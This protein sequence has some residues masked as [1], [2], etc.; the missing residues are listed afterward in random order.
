V[1]DRASLRTDRLLLEPIVPKHAESM[2]KATEPSLPE[3]RPWLAWAGTA[4]PETTAAFTEEARQD[5]A[6]GRAY[7]FAILEGDDVI[8]ALGLDTPIPGHRIG[9]L[10]YWV[11]TDRSA[12]GFATE[13]SQA[14]LAFGFSTLDLYRIELRAGVE[15]RA[16][17]RVA[18][19][20]RFSR[21]G[22]LHKGC[23][24]G[25]HPYDCFLYA[26]L[27]EDFGPSSE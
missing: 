25:K 24:G 21:E 9:D 1:I 10:G 26:L 7:Q 18:E 5:W 22:R 6:E 11:R 2:W 14:V 12:R 4:S 27:A 23:P 8:G 20:L 13:A 15:N 17:Q 19:R 3:L 16:S